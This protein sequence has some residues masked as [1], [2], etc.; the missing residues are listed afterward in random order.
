MFEQ[1]ADGKLGK[2]NAGV[3]LKAMHCM[4][5]GKF[6]LFSGFYNIAVDW[7]EVALIKVKDGMDTTVEISTAE[8]TLRHAM[9]QVLFEPKFV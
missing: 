9:H 7:L 1:I 3:G 6:A 5:I 8:I 4:Q 2:S